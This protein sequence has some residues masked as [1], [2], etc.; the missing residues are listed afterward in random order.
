MRVVVKC[1]LCAMRQQCSS[2]S[3]VVLPLEEDRFVCGETTRH[4]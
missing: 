2:C 1:L 3:L 4:Q